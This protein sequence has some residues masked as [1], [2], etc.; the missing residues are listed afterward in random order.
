MPQERHRLGMVPRARL[1]GRARISL[2]EDA[3][4]DWYEYDND[5]GTKLI[6]AAGLT[7]ARWAQAYNETLSGFA[8]TLPDA[9]IAAIKAKAAHNLAASIS[10]PSRSR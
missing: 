10:R 5:T 6:Q 9:E 4:A 3:A 1:L 8:G 7:P 2:D